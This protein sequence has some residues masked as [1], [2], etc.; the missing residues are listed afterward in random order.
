M[1]I[2]VA[3]VTSGPK[4]R[5]GKRGSCLGK[6]SDIYTFSLLFLFQKVQN[7]HNFNEINMSQ[8]TPKTLEI[9]FPRIWIKKKNPSCS[10]LRRSRASVT[11]SVW[12]RPW[13]YREQNM[14]KHTPISL[15]FVKFYYCPAFVLY[16]A[17][18]IENDKE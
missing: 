4:L 13:T 11:I 7:C 15:S 17:L 8:M 5:W 9:A 2:Y 1:M 6:I 14:I 3:I 10:R 18:C 12:L 16:W